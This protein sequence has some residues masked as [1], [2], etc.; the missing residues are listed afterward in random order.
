MVVYVT[1]GR[2][3]YVKRQTVLYNTGSCLNVCAVPDSLQ[4]SRHDGVQS[5]QFGSACRWYLCTIYSYTKRD[6]AA[7][8]YFST[9]AEN[10]VRKYCGPSFFHFFA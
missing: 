10:F 3:A 4:K 6:G 5:A 8:G 2:S 1:S 9:V 7:L